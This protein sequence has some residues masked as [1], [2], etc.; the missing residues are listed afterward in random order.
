MAMN[1]Q[2]VFPKAPLATV[3]VTIT[4]AN[5]AKDGTGTVNTI[6]TAGADGA[7][8][9]KVICMPLGTNVASVLRLFLNNGSSNAVAA[10]NQLIASVSLPATTLSEVAKMLTAPLEVTLNFGIPAG[11]KINAVIGTAVAAGW[12][13]SAVGGSY[14]A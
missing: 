11:Y 2:P 14:T 10:N 7:R 13:V 3:G 12:A 8:V 4:A 6:L 1:T 9:D 5:T